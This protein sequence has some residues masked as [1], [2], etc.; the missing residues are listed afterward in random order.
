MTGSPRSIHSP[1]FV[2]RRSCTATVWAGS[3]VLSDGVGIIRAFMIL[4]E[5]SYREYSA[6]SR[7]T[8]SAVMFIYGLSRSVMISFGHGGRGPS[9]SPLLANNSFTP[10]A[11]LAI[12]LCS[13]T[14]ARRISLGQS[15]VTSRTP[16]MLSLEGFEFSVEALLPCFAGTVGAAALDRDKL[17]D[18]GLGDVRLIEHLLKVCHASEVFVSLCE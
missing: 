13:S 12:A 11:H 7:I 10:F 5:S 18:K 2:L 6:L 9:N 14:R 8:R 17:H 16:L 4:R 3:M 1:C 15:A